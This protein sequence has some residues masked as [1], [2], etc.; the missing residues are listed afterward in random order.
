MDELL[1]AIYARKSLIKDDKD[2][3]GCDSQ[4]FHC[5]KHADDL[6]A[7]SPGKVVAVLREEGRSA[8][9]ENL[10]RE[11]WNKLVK[12]VQERKVNY[13]IVREQS[14]IT[15]LF[16]VLVP[17]LVFTR[18]H[19]TVAYDY[20]EKRVIS[21]RGN[22]KW[23]TVLKGMVNQEESEKLGDRVR[24]KMLYKASQGEPPRGRLRKFG[25][26]H[27]YVPIPKEAKVI[28]YMAK[29]YIGGMSFNALARDLNAKGWLHYTHTQWTQDKVRR[30]LEA[31]EYAGMRS[32]NGEIVCE[33]GKWKAI[34]K[35]AQH[36]Q[37]KER[38]SGNKPLAADSATKYLLVGVLKCGLCGK[39]LRA[40][41][42]KRTPAL[43]RYVCDSAKTGCGKIAVKM[44]PV[45]KL[46]MKLTYGAIALLPAVVGVAEPDFTEEAVAELQREREDYVQ[47][48]KANKLTLGDFIDFTTDL[49]RRISE[50]RKAAPRPVLVNDAQEFLDATTDKQRAVIGRMWY[51]AIKSAGRHGEPFTKERLDYAPR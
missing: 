37:I 35:P 2:I 27:A 46:V 4:I 26:T 10:E 38:M 31:P 20:S 18:T 51:L 12:L 16:E 11:E 19:D 40:Q 44:A 6:L 7:Q 14:R 43:N 9:K 39:P 13:I 28:R 45:D 41:G 50:L 34:F 33:K 48:R 17:F 15:R 24:D 22:D 49:D 42:Y 1:I 21:L 5:Q 8:F 3:E 29:A 36:E 32:F 30:I 23:M 47:A 25:Y